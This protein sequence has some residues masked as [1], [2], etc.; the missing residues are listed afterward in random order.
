MKCY[1]YVSG[2]PRNCIEE[3]VNDNTIKEYVGE[4]VSETR[5]ECDKLDLGINFFDE[6]DFN[7]ISS[8]D[9]NR[10]VLVSKVEVP[11]EVLIERFSHYYSVRACKYLEGIERKL[12]IAE[13]MAEQ[14]YKL[15]FVSEE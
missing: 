1:I 4:F 7:I 3:E 15:K 13:K 14:K 8:L 11:T 5:V 6:I 10:V 9:E 12:A 2:N